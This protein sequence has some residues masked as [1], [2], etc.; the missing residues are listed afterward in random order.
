MN[1]E[2]ID[3]RKYQLDSFILMEQICSKVGFE[4]MKNVSRMSEIYVLYRPNSGS[5]G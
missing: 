3:N 2:S 5:K 4:I 1:V